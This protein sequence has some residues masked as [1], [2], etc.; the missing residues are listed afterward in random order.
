MFER[1]TEK[2][3]RV[4]FFSRY[5]ASQYGSPEIDTE[6][7]LLGLLRENK[8]LYGWFPRATP[9]TLRQRINDC[10]AKLPST[11]TSGDLPLSSE[12]RRVLKF[13]A[14]EAD[15]LAQRHIGTEHLFLGLL[16]EESC[17]AAQ[18]LREAGADADAIRAQIPNSP[19]QEAESFASEMRRRAS[20]SL[21]RTGAIEIH[22]I[23]RNTELVREAVQRCRMYNWHWQKRPWTNTDIVIER[24]TGKVSFDLNLAADSE[25]FELVKGGWKK[26]RCFI[27]RWELFE[28]QSDADSDHGTGYTNGH[29]WLCTECYTKFWE[30]PDF[31]SSSYSDIT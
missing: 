23:R 5:E 31:F 14:D 7:L 8:N 30:R 15:R 2:A 3:R 12:A 28:S 16:D 21:L 10:S 11:P 20:S 27:C 29:D 25:K 4:I 22:G 9:E 1:Y 17:F 24:K 6:H 18:L 26:G 19:A 13:A